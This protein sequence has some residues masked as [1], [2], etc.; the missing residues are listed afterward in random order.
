MKKL[1]G[2]IHLVLGLASG[3][4]VF[5]VAITGA[6]WTFEQEISDWVYPYRRLAASGQPFLPPS[7]LM[8]MAQPHL[9]NRAI[10]AIDYPGP[11]RAAT[12]RARSA[13]HQP[14]HEVYLN[15]Y[16]AQVRHVKTSH[17]FFDLV[18]DLH[19]NLMLGQ[20]GRQVVDFATL[21]CLVLLATGLVLW[22]PKN[23]PAAKQR[24]WFR[25]K[26][27]LKWKRKNYD[28][29]NILG[30]YASWVAVFVVI[31]GLAWGFGWVNRGLYWLASGGAAYVDYADPKPA[32]E[33]GQPLPL[34]TVADRAYQQT[35]DRYARPFA[36]ISL[37]FPPDTAKTGVISCYINPSAVTYYKSSSYY[38]HRHSGTPLLEEHF[39][40]LNNGQK[41][42]SLYYDIH[43]GKL[44]GLP[45]QLL[46][47]FASLVVASLPITGFYVWYG[48]R[49]KAIARSSSKTRT[50][51][52][53][54]VK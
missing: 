17:G 54:M 45:G 52:V 16:T 9:G 33:P 7:E 15:P 8:R 21:F 18:L 29:H 32:P 41:L 51:R 38:Y 34:A 40:Q 26:N 42:R 4:V 6:I 36:N 22:W 48:R 43:I 20:A 39:Q 25:W 27:G 49:Y 44:L 13:D 11:D 31:T 1:I 53:A 14:P 47:F 5:V 3:L 46:V 30:F 19:V 50:A 12:V 24:L 2:K 23:R 35:V 28:L 37:Y 10:Q